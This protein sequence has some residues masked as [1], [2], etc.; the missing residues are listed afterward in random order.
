MNTLAFYI[1]L[2]VYF[3]Y[4]I[5]GNTEMVNF[6]FHMTVLLGI[7]AILNRR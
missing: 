7:L 3:Y 5:S 2:F 4:L 6:S 1:S